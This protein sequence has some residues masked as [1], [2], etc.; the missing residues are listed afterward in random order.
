MGVDHYSELNIEIE[1]YN[2]KFEQLYPTIR[3]NLLLKKYR[4]VLFNLDQCGY[5]KI[6]LNT[7][8]NIMGTWEKAEIFLVFAI[9]GMT[10]YLSP[11]RNKNKVQLLDQNLEKEIYRQIEQGEGINKAEWMGSAERMI[12]NHLKGYANYSSPFSINNPDG[13][14][15][16]LVHFANSYRAREVYNDVLHDNAEEQAHFG[17]SGLNMLSY[18][19]GNEGKLYLFNND[20]REDAKKELYNDIPNL[21]NKYSNG[22]LVA[23][24]CASIYNETAAHSDDIREMIIENSDIEVITPKKG[25]RKKANTIKNSDLLRLKKQRSFSFGSFN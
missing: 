10:T 13:W 1:F 11:D 2:Q 6:D 4:N 9:E 20:A 25:V 23:D 14:R 15:Y 5:S 3:N 17:R 21:L 12:F 8:Q 24:F 18:N 16:W 7:I 19:S 22:I